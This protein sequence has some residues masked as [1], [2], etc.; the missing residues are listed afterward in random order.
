[1]KH[2]GIYMFAAAW[3]IGGG[4]MWA[5]TDYTGRAAVER[6][7]E[8]VG[9]D[10]KVQLEIALDSLDMHAQHALV[11][12]PV[13]QA[14]DG[15]TE[16]ALAPVVVN[17]RIR[18]K[19]YERKTALGYA[20][21]TETPYAVVRRKN[22]TS[23]EVAY[24]VAVPYEKWMRGANLL[25][26]EEAT[27][28][29]ACSLNEY[30][31]PLGVILPWREIAEPVYQVAFV[32]PRAEEVKRRDE[33]CELHLN[34]RV[35]K[36]EIVLSLGNNR[37]EVQKLSD[38]VDR[39]KQNNDFT[40]TGFRIKGYA[41]PEGTYKSN[42]SLSERRAK[43]LADYFRRTDGWDAKL[44]T[45]EWGGEDWEGLRK[46]VEASL[47]DTKDQVLAVI[48]EE[49]NPD[50]RDAKLRAIDGGKTYSTL[51]KDFYPPLRRSFCVVDFT[52]RPYTLEEAK[53]IINENPR[54]LSLK[55]MYGVAVSYP[56]GSSERDEA[57]LTAQRLYPQDGDAATN[58]A[59]VLLA[60]GKTAEAKT[61]LIQATQTASVCNAL[62]IVYAKEKDYNQA[63]SYFAKAASLGNV[64]AQ[65]NADAL[66]KYIKEFNENNY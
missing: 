63:E 56:E 46:A 18:Q 65:H 19:A 36:S 23:Q 57:F 43:A 54:L 17:G 4:T 60:Q 27:G 50:A 35:G 15:K 16:K 41:S 31:R 30:E 62:G 38:M 49:E 44:F 10:V 6:S 1:M 28:C 22:G 33:Q 26:R 25:L 20:D 45:V 53:R 14:K 42:M 40:I 11:L 47:L 52:V 29:A 24:E 13:L 66:K 39:V 48:R 7:V 3:L 61:I 55:E 37:A 64:E 32:E 21:E 9:G 5:Q 12:T 59:K 34:Y 2:S 51:L 58:A 8:K